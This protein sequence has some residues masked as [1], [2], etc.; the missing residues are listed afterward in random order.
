LTGKWVFAQLAKNDS[1]TLC[2]PG[3]RNTMAEY[4]LSKRS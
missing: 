2:V 4:P 1:H 3:R